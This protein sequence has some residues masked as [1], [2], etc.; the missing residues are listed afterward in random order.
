MDIKQL[1]YF[2]GILEAKSITRAAEVLNMAQP[3]IGMQ[4]RKLEEE[5]G[6]E[7]VV[8]HS[9]G[10]VPT[11]AGE[12]LRTHAEN[13]LEGL[14]VA[15]QDILDIGTEYRGRVTVGMTMTV[16]H[17]LFA[18]II[19]EF[20]Q[21]Y[22][23]VSLI[24]SEGVSERLSK[25]LV[26]DELDIVFTYSPPTDPDFVAEALA[27]ESQCLAVPIG[28]PLAGKSGVTLREALACELV[29][30]SPFTLQRIRIDET[31]RMYGIPLRVVCEVNSIPALREFV[32]NGLGCAISPYGAMISDV[33]D[34]HIAML[35]IK[36]GDLCRT[37]HI[38]C[39]KKR[40]NSIVFD[41]IYREVQPIVDGIIAAGKAG[42][43]AP[44][45]AGRL[46]SRPR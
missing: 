23:A 4:L 1:R 15:R 3:A 22:P 42:W 33:E 27:I 28:H 34:G 35:P 14:A 45:K 25:S 7:L 19:R 32:Y 11:E 41:A 18:P 31:A 13:I 6:V 40:R 24:C 36:E 5:L 39:S 46:Q 43:T 16:L 2:L 20:R 37:L 12:R 8:R 29:V 30:T 26:A 17:L 21:K 44:P 10:I 38:A 9:R